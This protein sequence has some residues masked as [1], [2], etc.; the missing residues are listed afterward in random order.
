MRREPAT[1]CHC[2]LSRS[3]IRRFERRCRSRRGCG[4]ELVEIRASGTVRRSHAP[5]VTFS[6]DEVRFDGCRVT[7]ITLRF[8]PNDPQYPF[9]GSSSYEGGYDYKLQRK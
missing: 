4:L 8:D 3:G 6:A 1:A 9:T 7:G 5:V 2:G